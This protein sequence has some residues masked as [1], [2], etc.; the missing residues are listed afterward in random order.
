MVVDERI[1]HAARNRDLAYASGARSCESKEARGVCRGVD[2]DI[3]LA[4]AA[5]GV[6]P[7]RRGVAAGKGELSDARSA[8]LGDRNEPCGTRIGLSVDIA[9]IGARCHSSGASD[10]R[11]ANAKSPCSRKG[12]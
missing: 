6:A 7:Y 8:C 2:V 9:E 5:T 11:L 3:A 10:G 4:G 1:G 12:E